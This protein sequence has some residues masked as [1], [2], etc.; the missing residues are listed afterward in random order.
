M[1]E[2]VSVEIRK[3][4]Q[5]KKRFTAFFKREN[6]KIKK[7]HFGS[8]GANTFIDGAEEK[9]KEN[10]LKRHKVNE[11]WDDPISAGALSRWIIWGEHRNVNKNIVAFRKKFNLM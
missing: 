2:F 5:P 3:S 8:E 4:E 11:N 10:Y 9:V 1:S 6:G 7:V